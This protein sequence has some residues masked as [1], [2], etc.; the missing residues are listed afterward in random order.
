MIVR[1][2]PI[3]NKNRTF[4]MKLFGLIY[5]CNAPHTPRPIPPKRIK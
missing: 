2:C 1:E 3:C 5:T 4:L